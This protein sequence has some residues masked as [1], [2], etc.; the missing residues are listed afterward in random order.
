M[1]K[2]CGFFILIFG[3]LIN[4]LSQPER[5]EIIEKKIR[6]IQRTIYEN[7]D[8]AKKEVFQ[9]FYSLKGDDSVELYNGIVSFKYIAKYDDRGRT[10]QLIRYDI[11]GNQ[12]EWHKYNYNRDGSYS[13]EKIAQGAGTISLAQYNKK[14]WLMEEEIE[15]SYSMIYQ[16]NA[17]GKTRKV[18]VKEKGKNST[19]EIAVFYFD[20]N[21]FITRG[22]GTTGGGNTVY[23]KYNDKGLA[24]EVKTVFG[25][26]KTK[27]TTETM[28]LAYEFY[29]SQN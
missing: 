20:K 16:R 6:M 7:G 25:D 3:F 5:D 18:L 23:F 1:K 29:E 19:E 17:S 12:D 24:N 22:E 11:K 9:N 2:I 28:L 8:T 14:N 13:I 21:G 15:S 26:K 4:C 27:Q 10:D